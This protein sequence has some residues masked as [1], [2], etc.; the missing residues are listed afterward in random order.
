MSTLD[1]DMG[2]LVRD[3]MC[4]LGIEVR[5]GAA[6]KGIEVG[7]DGWVGAVVTDDE[8]FPADVV[9]LGLGTRPNSGLARDAG[10][11]IGRSGGIVTDRRMRVPGHDGIWAGGDCVESLHLVSGEP[12]SIPL[13][14]HANKQGRVAGINLGGG[15]AT[16]AGVVGTAI[17]KV[18]SLE[19]ARTGLTEREAAA[20]GFEARAVRIDTTTIAGYMPD[21]KPMAIKM[22]GE[23]G[24][25]RLLGAQIVGEERSAKRIDTVATALHAGFRVDELIDLD[26]AYAPPFSSTWDPVHLAA[27]R[28]VNDL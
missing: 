24:T 21:T 1:P 20:E 23:L 12:V 17:T 26:L 4:G 15:Y 7:E 27:R 16:F 28:L 8:T 6:V 14:T 5:T 25:G 2:A 22:V 10:L 3:A 13:G 18:C 19:V 11:P 9:V